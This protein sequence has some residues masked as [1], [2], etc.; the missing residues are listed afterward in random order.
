MQRSDST[1]E[2]QNNQPEQTIKSAGAITSN[3]SPLYQHCSA[4]KDGK[5]QGGLL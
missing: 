4:A 5:F 3:P 1:D 2:K